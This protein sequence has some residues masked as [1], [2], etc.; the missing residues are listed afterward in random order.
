[1]AGKSKTK[2]VKGGTVENCGG[3]KPEKPVK[4]KSTGKGKSK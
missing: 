1:M 3:I 4:P 2:P